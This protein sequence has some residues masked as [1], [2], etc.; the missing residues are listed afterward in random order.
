MARSEILEGLSPPVRGNLNSCFLSIRRNGSIPA[1]A[2]EPSPLRQRITSKKVYPRPCGGTGWRR[3]AG[4]PG[5]GL[6]PP[7]RGNLADV[8]AL[9]DRDGSIPARAGEP[10]S[11][12]I[13]LARRWVYPRPCG[14]TQSSPP[15]GTEEAGLSPPVRGNRSHLDGEGT[16]TGSIP[17]RAG[18]PRL[19]PM[20]PS[21]ITVYPRPCGGTGTQVER[22]QIL[23]GLSPPVRGNPCDFLS[24]S[25]F[26]GSIP[27][28]AGEPVGRAI[29]Y[30]ENGVYPR[31]CGGT[32]RS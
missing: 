2:G 31:P 23:E 25:Q 18:E 16:A 12:L 32:P 6:S 13:A 30:F 22:G 27:A 5:T 19:C 1:R 24:A 29:V 4:T 21:P 7:V 8:A 9:G 26:Q 10:A 17:A 3:V 20:S 11:S 14:G 28:R 15:L